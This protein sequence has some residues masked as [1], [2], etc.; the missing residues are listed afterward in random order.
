[1]RRGRGAREGACVQ[2]LRC[3]SCPPFS[4][5]ERARVPRSEFEKGGVE[6]GERMPRVRGAQRREADAV[7]PVEVRAW[8]Y[9]CSKRG[10]F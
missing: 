6:V 5:L 8:R 3:V 1:M 9:T 2:A 10:E 7:A 4:F